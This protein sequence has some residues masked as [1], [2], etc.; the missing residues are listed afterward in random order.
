MDIYAV[1]FFAF[2]AGFLVGRTTKTSD[3]D[4]ASRALTPKSLIPQDAE[5]QIRDLVRRG[6]KLRPSKS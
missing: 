1:G 4:S 6:K 2:V 3:S 5:A